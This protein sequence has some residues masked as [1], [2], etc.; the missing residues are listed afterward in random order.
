METTELYEQLRARLDRLGSGY[1]KTAA[2]TEYVFLKRF[3]T[4]EDAEYIL[5][6]PD[7]FFT[8]EEYAQANA[9]DPEQAYEKIYD[10]SKRG[11]VYREKLDGV[12][13][14]HL[15]PLVH[16]VYEFNCNNFEK[17]WLDPFFAS[18]GTPGWREM[19]YGNRH[20]PF[21]RALPGNRR[22][23]KDED[24]GPY[25]DIETIIANSYA[26]ALTP[27]ACRTNP[28][29][30]NAPSCDCPTDTCLVLDG[31]ADYAV[32]N[33][34]GYYV[35]KEEALKVTQDGLQEDRVIE[36]INSKIAEVICSCCSCGC[37][38]IRGRKAFGG[39]DVWSNYYVKRDPEKC[40]KCG[41]CSTHC[42]VDAIDG[43]SIDLTHCV[44]CGI[45]VN[46]CPQKALILVKKENAYVPP[47]RVFDAYASM[48]EDLAYVKECMG[49]QTH[50]AYQRI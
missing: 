17:E 29:Y 28:K 14:F 50:D 32:E 21:F 20:T 40:V 18:L 31:F 11:L 12:Y 49:W 3:F 47:D 33:G 15:I 35:T 30:R 43:E 8:A 38:I 19:T 34:F 36:A 26:C 10:M 13:H 6:M 41:Q 22:L 39:M 23:V 48:T 1:P 42:Q 4:P 45:C 2:G 44:G 27:C 46:K 24:V 16:G 25:D 5:R 37:G 7:G 9:T